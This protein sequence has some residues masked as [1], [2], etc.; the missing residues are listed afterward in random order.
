M[1]CSH[2]G[3]ESPTTHRAP[4]HPSR[5]HIGHEILLKHASDGLRTHV[6]T[7]TSRP[8][9][10]LRPQLRRLSLPKPNEGM[11]NTPEHA[12]QIHPLLLAPNSLLNLHVRPRNY[13]QFIVMT[14]HY[15]P[16][17]NCGN[18]YGYRLRVEEKSI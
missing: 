14:G 15:Q 8:S 3:K 12:E 4:E 16:H 10:Q 17:A 5:L 1:V 11:A 18:G 6:D 7:P 13:S 2:H 9:Q